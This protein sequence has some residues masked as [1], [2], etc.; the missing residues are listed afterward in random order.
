[1]TPDLVF[2]IPA[3]PLLVHA[4]VVPLPLS[5]IGMIV[6]VLVPKFRGK[7]QQYF[8]AGALIVSA[9]SAYVTKESGQILNQVV[10]VSK[11]HQE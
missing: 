2:G 4:V 9:V 11:D 6:M 1:M 10:S 7:V 5:A 3:H 8:V